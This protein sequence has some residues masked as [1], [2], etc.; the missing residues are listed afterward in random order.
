MKDP[1]EK[2]HAEWGLAE[3]RE[4]FPGLRLTHLPDCALQ[5]D[6]ELAF[7]A[8]MDGFDEID[9]T[10]KLSGIIPYRFPEEEA[11]VFEVGGRIS[12][13]YHKFDNGIL[14]LG[15]P[16]RRRKELAEQPTLTGLIERLV[17]PYL[18]NHSYQERNGA[19]PVGELDHGAPG[20]VEDYE[21]LFQLEGPQQCLEA[22]QLLGMK[23]RIA[24]KRACPCGSGRRLG[25]CH[26][27][28]LN[29]F[30]RFAPRNY[31]RRQAVYLL[32]EL[33]RYADFA[34]KQRGGLTKVRDPGLRE[35]QR[36]ES[37]SS[38]LTP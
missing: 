8:R 21:K 37:Q 15:S 11:Q 19:L 26:N 24:N 38:S 4:R 7:R 22:L 17:I 9:D 28:Q 16:I 29:P 32:K 13:D 34:R 1:C 27:R 14:C 33:K 20:L 12:G 36:E 25:R 30:R 5:F 2:R 6:G 10:Y 18:Y 31:F 35:H 3:F 23:K